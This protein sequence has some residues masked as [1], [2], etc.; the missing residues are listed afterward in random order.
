MK[1]FFKILK[2]FTITLVSVIVLFILYALIRPESTFDAPYPEITAS[3]DSSVIARG[4]YLVYGPAHCAYCHSTANEFKRVEAGEVVPL[5]GGYLFALPIGNI[6]SPNITSDKNTGIGS[7]TDGELA[8]TLRYGVKRNG[9]ALLDFMPFY[10]LSDE[11]LTAIISYL[12]SEP[13]V[14]NSVPQNEWSF[15][16]KIIKAFG[17]IKPMGDGVVPPSPEPDSTAEYGKYLAGS[18][19]NCR[20]CHTKR[21]MT[22]GSYIGV[23]YAGNMQF[24]VLDENGKIIP[25]KHIVS[26]NLTP[27]KGTGRIAFWT[28]DAFVKR[29]QAGRMIQGSPMPWGAFSRLNESDLIAIYKYLKTLEPVKSQTPSG[30]QE[31]DPE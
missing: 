30:V 16:G 10:D 26:P 20:G 17:M 24:E 1:K 21:D 31:G 14:N 4:K 18:V 27:D 28:Q 3:K 5:S 2:W 6:Y 9:H 13:A 25:G 15:L 23:D 7:Y 8:R 29:F 12:R 22:D 11:D 19:A